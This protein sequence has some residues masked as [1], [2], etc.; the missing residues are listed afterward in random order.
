MIEINNLRIEDV[1]DKWSRL[2]ANIRFEGM[3]SPY[4]E[5]R[6]WFSVRKEDREMLSENN[7]DPFFL[8][9]L[10]LAMYHKQDLH[11]AGNVSKRLYKNTMSYIQ[12]I[13]CDFSDNLARVNITVDGFTDSSSELMGGVLSERESPVELIL[14]VQY[15]ITL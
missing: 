7:Y 12:K 6:I 9:P 13:L 8:V 14:F 4:A 10:Y 1:D 3:K 11:I 5:E 2:V 15:M